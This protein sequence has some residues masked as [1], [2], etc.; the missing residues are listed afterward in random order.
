MMLKTAA[1]NA[2]DDDGVKVGG[3][4]FIPLSTDDKDELKALIR[5]YGPI[6]KPKEKV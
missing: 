6:E 4:Y 1:V 5:I 2:T 3:P